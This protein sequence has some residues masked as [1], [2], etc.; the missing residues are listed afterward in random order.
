M[1]SFCDK[2]YFNSKPKARYSTTVIKIQ[3]KIRNYHIA[4]YFLYATVTDPF[5]RGEYISYVLHVR[6]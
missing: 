3:T 4:S 5:M 6:V 2:E 1:S